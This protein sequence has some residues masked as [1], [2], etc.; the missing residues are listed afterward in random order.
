LST[1]TLYRVDETGAH[2][3]VS[4]HRSLAEG[5]AAGQDA[6]HADAENAYALYLAGIN[7]PDQRVA[8][9]GFSRLPANKFESIVAEMMG[10]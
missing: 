7:S 8:R 6:V 4:E 9:F 5:W 3:E 10:S 2:T 1:F